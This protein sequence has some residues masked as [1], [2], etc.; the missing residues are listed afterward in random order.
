MVHRIRVIRGKRQ[1]PFDAY[2]WMD[3]LHRQVGLH[4]LYFFLVAQ[5]K[6]KYDRNIDPR[7]PAFQGLVRDTAAK[8]TVG[9]HPSWAS[10]DHQPLLTKEK[11]SLERLTETTITASRQHYLRFGLPATYRRLLA[12]GIQ[13]E[14]SMGYGTING[15][16]ASVATPF[17]WYDLKNESKASLR[18]HPFCFMDANAYYEEKKEAGEALQDLLH[19]YDVIRSVNGTMITVWHN[20]FLGTDPQFDG[21][22]EVYEE[23]VMKASGS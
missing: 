5:Q 16:R 13:D 21:W 17:Y 11:S 18:I 15:F 19:Y 6:G 10:G 23:F 20:N 14:Y 7:N 3:D 9:L 22:R 4:P 2:E 1:D 12:I 8:Y